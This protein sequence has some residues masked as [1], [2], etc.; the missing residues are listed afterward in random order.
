MY[1]Y[2]MFPYSYISDYFISV[3][4]ETQTPITNLKLQKLV[5]YSQ[6][7]SLA[8]LGKELIAEDF[9]AWVHGPVLPAL[10]AEYKEFGWKPIYRE[11]LNGVSAQQ[12]LDRLHED[13]RNVLLD[14]EHEH[15]GMTAYALE[16]QTHNEDPWIIS[17]QGI[18][19][20]APCDFII[21]KKMMQDYY[22]RFVG[23]EQQNL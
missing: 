6:A 21:P 8:L 16:T 11:E 23:H 13:F 15:F 22:S 20:D 5:Y 14:V 2:A 9:Q 3:A 10:Y 7:W 1:L 17:R 18:A 19:D 12:I 4:N